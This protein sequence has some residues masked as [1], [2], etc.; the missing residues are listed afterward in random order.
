L[1]GVKPPLPIGIAPVPYDPDVDEALEHGV[2]PE[3][4]RLKKA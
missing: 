3:G 4:A 2:V 1:F